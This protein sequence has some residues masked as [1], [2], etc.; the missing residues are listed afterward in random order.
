MNWSGV[1]LWEEQSIPVF[2]DNVGICV[3]YVPVLWWFDTIS[4][5]EINFT[6]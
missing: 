1:L 3:R 6:W 5:S 2:P 4:V